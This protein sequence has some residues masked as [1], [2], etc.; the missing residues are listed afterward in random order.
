VAAVWALSPITTSSPARQ[1]L[2]EDAGRLIAVHARGRHLRQVA[3]DPDDAP[4]RMQRLD[5]LAYPALELADIRLIGHDRGAAGG[6]H[7]PAVLAKLGRQQ[8]DEG[9][10]ADMRIAADQQ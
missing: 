2:V 1:D 5:D 7:G 3:D 8:A 10:L 6:E 9:G 4:P